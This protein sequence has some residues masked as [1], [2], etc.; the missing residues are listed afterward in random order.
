M[1]EEQIEEMD[2]LENEDAQSQQ[3]ETEQQETSEQEE[4][5]SEA[6]EMGMKLQEA[7]DK[8]LRLYSEF[9]NFRKRTAKEKLDTIKSASADL[10]KQLLPIM[11]DFERAIQANEEIE[12]IQVV[13]EGFNL[14]QDKLKKTLEAKGVKEIEAKGEIFDVDKHEA[15]T[16][17]PGEKNMKGKV[18]D[19]IEKG[20]YMNDTVIRY[21]KVVVGQ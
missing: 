19:V 2:N 15:L 9:E 14:I 18:I 10:A 11:D 21:A 16:Q 4:P 3:E 20:Y 13:K 7:Q 8:Y 17:V 6:E 5:R 12:D 1:A